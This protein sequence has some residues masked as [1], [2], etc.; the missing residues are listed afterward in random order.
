MACSRVNFTFRIVGRGGAIGI[1][2]RCGLDVI[3]LVGGEIF[4]TP[5][6]VQWVPGFFPR[7]RGVKQ[8]GRG[9]DHPPT[10][11]AEVKERVK[12]YLSPLL[13]FKTSS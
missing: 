2:T 11:S 10:S 9:V 1:A 13:A 7:W 8:P 4:R 3:H 12:L 5:P 6:P